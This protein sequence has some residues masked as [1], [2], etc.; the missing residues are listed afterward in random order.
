MRVPPGVANCSW[1]R[2]AVAGRR[3]RPRPADRPPPAPARAR[4]SRDRQSS[5]PATTSK[6]PTASDRERP[7]PRRARGRRLSAAD[8]DHPAHPLGVD[9]RQRL[10]LRGAGRRHRR[11]CL[12]S[13]MFATHGSCAAF[14]ARHLAAAD[15]Q[16]PADG[17]RRRRRAAARSPES[18]R[19][20]ARRARGSRAGG[21]AGGRAPARRS[22]APARPTRCRTRPVSP[23]TPRRR[24]RACGPPAAAS[25]R[26]RC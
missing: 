18:S 25:G 20:R 22:I 1:R 9:R 19:L 15:R 11:S 8:D 13:V 17:H 24:R 14:D 3:R 26:G 6:A 2:S 23:S 7:Q 4:S 12:R 5:S 16:V 21:A 10:R